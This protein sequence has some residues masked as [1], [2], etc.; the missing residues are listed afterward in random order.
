MDYLKLYEAHSLNLNPKNKPV[1]GYIAW[2][3]VGDDDE[4]EVA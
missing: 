4:V 2:A 1:P 3:G